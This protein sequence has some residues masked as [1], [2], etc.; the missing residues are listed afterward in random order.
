MD[1]TW[2]YVPGGGTAVNAGAWTRAPLDE[3]IAASSWVKDMGL[4]KVRPGWGP[5]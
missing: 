1:V 5:R 2:H 3:S 4:D